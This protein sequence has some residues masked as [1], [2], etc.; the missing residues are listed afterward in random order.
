MDTRCGSISWSRSRIHQPLL[1]VASDDERARNN[2]RIVIYEIDRLRQL[3]RIVTLRF[4]L[5][6]PVTD[7]KFSPNGIPHSHELAVA[8]GVIHIYNIKVPNTD[9]V[10]NNIITLEDGTQ[11][12]AT[13]CTA[14]SATQV[15][16]L[17]G[18]AL[19]LR[20]NA[21][22]TMI[23]ADSGHGDVRAYKAM[24]GNKWTQ[25]DSWDDEDLEDWDMPKDLKKEQI[26]FDL[27][28]C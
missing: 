25:M 27:Y 6:L 11:T 4:D 26:I 10:N 18:K 5:A 12:N 14:Y 7:L 13:E 20:Y 23:V 19:R 9:S 2:E 1:A 3:H 22:G 21:G 24:L 16:V 15:V 8:A 17:D 28:H